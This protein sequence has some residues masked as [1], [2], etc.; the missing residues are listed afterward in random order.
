M[1][2]YIISCQKVLI[3]GRQESVLTQPYVFSKICHLNQVL[4]Q[5]DIGLNK[6]GVM[7]ADARLVLVNIKNRRLVYYTVISFEAYCLVK[8]YIVIGVWNVNLSL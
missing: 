6:T 5:T 2:R 3:K 8:L 7:I 4:C 1:P